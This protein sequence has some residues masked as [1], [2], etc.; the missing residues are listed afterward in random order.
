MIDHFA[1]NLDLL[2]ALNPDLAQRMLKQDWMEPVTLF[3]SRS[4]LPNAGVKSVDG[5]TVFL[6][7]HNPVKETIDFL[8][9]KLTHRKDIV[10]ICGFGLGYLP[11]AVAERLKPWQW[12][13]VVE[14]RA[15]IFH[16]AMS[17][18]DLG[19]VIGRPNT[20]ILVTQNWIELQEWLH[21]ILKDT[22]S[23]NMSILTHPV[24]LWIEREFYSC[25]HGE[26]QSAVGR[27][28]VE[29][30]TL[31]HKAA[32]M[33]RN[34]ILNI[35][36]IVESL[37]VND[38]RGALKG[39]P[40]V[41]IGAGPS[42]NEAIPCLRRIQDHVVVVACGKA[43]PI[44]VKE[45]IAPDFVVSLD[46]SHLSAP[47]FEGYDMPGHTALVFDPDGW[48]GIPSAHKGK[49]VTY[50]VGTAIN[51]WMRTFLHGRGRLE[52]G[53]S[54]AHSEFFFARACGCSPVILCGVDLSFPGENTHAQGA[55][56]TWGGKTENLG[57]WI[58][59]PAAG[60]GRVRTLTSFKAFITSF[61]TAI[62]NSVETKAVQTSLSGAYIRGC[63]HMS[64]EDAVSV[65][66]DFDVDAK[67]RIRPL[68]EMPVQPMDEK[69]LGG[70]EGA[71]SDVRKSREFAEEGLHHLRRLSRVDP[72]NKLE[73]RQYAK[74]FGEMMKC[75]KGILGI[76]SIRN[77]TQ[78]QMSETALLVNS[79]GKEIEV[80]G[81]ENM[82]LLARLERNKYEHFF[83]GHAKA[84]NFLEPE[85]KKILPKG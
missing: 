5:G 36:S 55:T 62:A 64:L 45:G 77:L 84:A 70:I 83:Q 33:D 59:V 35:P 63:E 56:M 17:A 37:G 72:T 9:G 79:I 20:L 34:G 26:I 6:H 27:S 67:S 4:G 16:A 2:K 29:L 31:I 7:G 50:D 18:M 49:K 23:E 22:E 54:V 47:C 42:L 61:E 38:F 51:N 46:M 81:K 68:L 11:L 85:L 58:Q 82:K 69:M 14:P 30:N 8:E 78:R 73:R 65:Y 44:L 57:K 21:K 66:V 75:S 53:L 80:L 48:H 60:G 40:A 76:P 1:N 71:I 12:L 28:V 10:F 41:V 52:K 13:L 25:I 15:D 74:I 39:L 3:E 32:D 43:M 24:N 19:K